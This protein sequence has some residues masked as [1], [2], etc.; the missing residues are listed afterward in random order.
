M[1]AFSPAVLA[2]GRILGRRGMP[3]SNPLH[4]SPK[5]V[6]RR[7]KSPSNAR[8]QFIAQVVHLNLVT[9]PYVAVNTLISLMVLRTIL[10]YS[11]I[12]TRRLAS[13]N[14]AFSPRTWRKRLAW[15]WVN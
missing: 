10:T 4:K 9:M 2:Y 7:S 14:T 12:P 13:L 1:V 8:Q 15:V 11:F 3:S 6:R 5:V